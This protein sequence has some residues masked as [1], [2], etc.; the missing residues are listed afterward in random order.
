MKKFIPILVFFLLFTLVEESTAD[1]FPRYG[2]LVQQDSTV[3]SVFKRIERGI[4]E[5]DVKIFSDF[6][7][8]E[9][10]LSLK[11]GISGYYSANQSYYILQ[12]YLTLNI[13]TEFKFTG[14]FTD[15]TTPYASGN[16]RYSHK[17]VRG[18]AQLFISLKVVNGSW[19]ISQ[20]TIN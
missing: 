1:Q 5:I 16:L 18:D 14:M 20:I 17:G 7:S 19:Q 15:S 12:D 8:T 10:Y 9:T 6:L 2:L 11:N 3:R 4:I 13:P